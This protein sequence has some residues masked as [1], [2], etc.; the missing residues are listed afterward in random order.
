MFKKKQKEKEEGKVEE[1]V[2]GPKAKPAAAKEK[3]FLGMKII[4]LLDDKYER[5]RG[6]LEK[7]C[8]LFEKEFLREVESVCGR[9]SI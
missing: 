2:A 4:N 9:R 5:R 6:Y 7:Y 8:S 3:L 1:L